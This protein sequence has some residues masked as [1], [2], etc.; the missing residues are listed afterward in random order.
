MVRHG[1]CWAPPRLGEIVSR[2]WGSVPIAKDPGV[3]VLPFSAGL[4]GIHDN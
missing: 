1:G 2:F 3:G 4:G